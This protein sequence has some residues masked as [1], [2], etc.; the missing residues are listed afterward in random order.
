VQCSGAGADARAADDPARPDVSERA[1]R[2]GHQASS[3]AR[4]ALARLGWVDA[5]V[6]ARVHAS[7]ARACL[8]RAWGLVWVVCVRTCAP[9]PHLHRGCAQPA[10]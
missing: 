3:R 4:S 1:G 7:S 5:C 6:R 2:R 9:P 8:E 10:T